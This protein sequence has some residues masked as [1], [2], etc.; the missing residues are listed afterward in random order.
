MDDRAIGLPMEFEDHVRDALLHLFDPAYLQTH[1]LVAISGA[2]EFDRIASGRRLRQ[3]LLD[4]IEALHP[5]PGVTT[6]SRAWRAYRIL[7][8]RYIGGLDVAHVIEQVALGERQYH[9]EHRRALQAV[10]S[11]LWE[12]WRLSDRWPQDADDLS[13]GKARDRGPAQLEAE[14]LLV[15]DGAGRVDLGEALAGVSALLEP[16]CAHLDVSLKLAA[17]EAAPAILG[18]R[19]AVRQALLT[20][21]S[22]AVSFATHETLEAT[23]VNRPPWVE[24]WVTSPSTTHPDSIRQAIDEC[25]PFVEA[26]KGE[27]TAVPPDDPSGRWRICLRFS[28]ANRPVL[29]VVDNNPDFIRLVER[30]LSGYEWQVVGVSAVDQ[31]FSLA[32]QQAPN[33]ILLDAVIPGRDGWDLLLELKKHAITREIPVIICSVLD[34]PGVALSLGAVAYLHKP[35]EQRQLLEALDPFR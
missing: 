30:Y 23:L 24:I 12:R 4:A 34:E 18:E 8:L 10:A 35:I 11:L 1:P 9:R 26:L 22:K 7:E 28:A 2:T 3:E 19:V 33:A 21:L 32:Q 16:L 20:V 17:G 5:G 27:I 29:L 15:Q 13:T 6:T 25:L 14:R 31:A